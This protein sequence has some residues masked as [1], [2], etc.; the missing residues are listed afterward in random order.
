MKHITTFFLSLVLLIFT[1]GCQKQTTYSP[2]TQS[3]IQMVESNPE[4]K[5]MLVQSIEKCKAL[6]PDTVTNPVQSLEDYYDFVEWSLTCNVWDILPQAESRPL[7]LRIDQSLNYFYWLVDQELDELQ[8]KGYYR[9]SL[10][11]HEPFRSWLIDYVK[12]WG[13]YLD[14]P[15]SWNDEYLAIA[16]ANEEFGLAQGW[17][18]DPS[19]WHSFNDFFSR[20]LASSDVRPIAEPDNDAVVCSPADSHPQGTWEI[21]STGAFVVDEGVIVKSRRFRSTQEILAN[22]AYRDSFCNGT[23]THTFLNVHDYHRYHFPVSGKILEILSIPGE[24]ALGGFVVF[25]PNTKTYVLECDE[26]TWQAIETRSL[27]VIQTQEYGIVAALPIG[28]SQV[29]SCMWEEGLHVGQEIKKGD[30]MGY[31]LFGGSDFMMLFQEGIHVDFTAPMIDGVPQH[32]LMGEEYGRLS[33]KN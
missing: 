7:L 22:S 16:M 26:P 17:Y 2:K 27:V 25:E 6:N 15:E 28:M 8:D 21:D 11:Y 33:R 18:E 9:A 31:F 24:C 4:M 12:T 13:Q 5:Q 3:F 20:H 10:Q 14:T 1:T 19:N 30:P 29:C 32:L 23:M